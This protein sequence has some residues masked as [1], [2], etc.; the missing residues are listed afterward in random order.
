MLFGGAAIAPDAAA[1]V[2]DVHNKVEVSRILMSTP[3]SLTKLG[4]E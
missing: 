3:K 1:N 4:T 2:R